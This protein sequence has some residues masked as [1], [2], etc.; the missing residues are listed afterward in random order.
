[1]RTYAAV[2]LTLLTASCLSA[3]TITFTFMGTDS[4]TLNG[5]AFASSPFT[6]TSSGDIANLI[7]NPCGGCAESTLVS[8]AASIAIAGL[9]TFDFTDPSQVWKDSSEV[10]FGR[11]GN[12]G[13]PV[14]ANLV[15]A[16]DIPAL[17]P[18]GE[19]TSIGP[20]VAGLSEISQWDLFSGVNTSGGVLIL[21]VNNTD[22]IT[23][24]AT[25]ATVTPE[26]SSFAFLAIGVA[27]GL[28]GMKLKAARS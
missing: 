25:A 1:M 15:T 6:I 28:V 18:W 21:D 8:D 5:V 14:G 3:G 7:P 12:P 23:F 10:G 13:D 16:Y 17:V 2:A 19:N 24:Q 22:P 4:G 11:Y 20:F 26:P 27:V 9:G